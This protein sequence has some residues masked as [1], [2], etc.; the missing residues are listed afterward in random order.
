MSPK[1]AM[2]QRIAS[3]L[4]A[5]GFLDAV[6]GAGTALERVRQY[7]ESFDEADPRRSA[8]MQYPDYPCF[9]GLRNE[10]FHE[11]SASPA[12][13]H[14]ES[15]FPDIAGDYRSLAD[16]DYMHYVP[17]AME[18]IWAVRLLW[19]M[20][21][22]LEPFHGGS[23]AT[24]EAVRTAPRACL[25]YPWGDALFSVHSSEA[26][27][28]AHC[29]VDN[30][31]LRCHLG[32]AVPPGCEIRVGQSKRTWREGRVL[33]FE[34]SFEHEVWNRGTTRRAILIM[35]TWHPDLTEAEIRAL[36]AAFRHS[37][38]RSL[39]LLERLGMLAG[40]APQGLANYVTAEMARQDADPALREYWRKPNHAG[41]AL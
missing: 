25:D 27:L 28:K 7:V 4:R 10:P 41:S 15:A 36:T 5:G 17:P 24:F 11:E 37:S 32:I 30:L 12:A 38:V 19:Y 13:H 33:Q 29:S 9:P 20:G 39:F 40:G 35:D 18:R 3:A 1:A 31:R 16:A 22:C 26:H 2:R 6:R 34:D 8:P 23:A 21:I 14:L